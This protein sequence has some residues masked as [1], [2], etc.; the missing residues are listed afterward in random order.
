MIVKN[1]KKKHFINCGN[2]SQSAFSSDA[3]IQ[4]FSTHIMPHLKRKCN[5]ILLIFNLILKI[6][7]LEA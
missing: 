2:N 5:R 1:Q 6:F 7:R 3:S 4:Y